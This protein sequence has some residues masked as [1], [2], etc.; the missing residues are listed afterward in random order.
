MDKKINMTDQI[1]QENI[2][3]ELQQEQEQ[4]QQDF[5]PETSENNAGLPKWVPIL[6]LAIIAV[7]AVG[8]WI[9]T[10]EKPAEDPLPVEPVVATDPEGEVHYLGILPL[11]NPSTMLERFSGIEEYLREETGLNI[12]LKFYPTSGDIGGYTAVVRDVANGVTS[13]AYLASVTT[14]QANGNGPV[15]P[16]I[17]AEKGGSPTYQG[18]LVVKE[19]SPYQ[20]LEDLEGKKVSGTSVSSTSGNL[21]PLAMLLQRDIDKETYFDGGIM[22]LGSHDKAADAVLLGTVDACFIN[23]ATFNKYKEKGL[24]SIW[25]HDPVPE[26]PFVVN[27]EKVSPEII[28]EVRTALL[29]MHETKLEGIQSINEKYEKW[30]G[31]DWEDYLGIKEAIDEVHGPVFY[32]LDEWGKSE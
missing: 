27:T 19:D 3:Q 15:V 22:Y 24:R 8:F 7:I 21:M 6:I 30:V 16:F 10:K 14:V 1:N 32:D 29:K 17:C 9:L 4:P 12:K 20:K 13:F 25:R 5:Q 28:E 31:I 2:T 26:F 11:R 23:E 18:D